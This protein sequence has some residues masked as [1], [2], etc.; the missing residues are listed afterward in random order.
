M[1]GKIERALKDNGY[2]LMH[3]NGEQTGYRIYYDS[4]ASLVNAV[5][6]V[7]AV[8]YN[9]E[10]STKF[11][12]ALSRQMAAYSMSTHFMTV[13]CVSGSP[14]KEI[15]EQAVVTQICED[16]SFC[17]VYDEAAEKL[18]IGEKQ[19]E[20]FYGLKHI[21][22][23][24]SGYEEQELEP[25]AL[26][27]ET[28]EKPRAKGNIFKEIASNIKKLPRA[29]SLLVFFNICIFVICTLTGP[30]LYNIGGAGLKLIEKP[31]D[32]YRIFTSMFLHLDAAHIF[33]NMVLLYFLGEIVEKCVGTKKFL[34]MYFFSGLWGC[35][36]T[37]FWEII[38]K[39]YVMVVGASGAIFGLLGGLFA[40]V[41]FKRIK[42]RT[43][44]VGRVFIVIIFSI[45]EG[46]AQ[47]NVANAAHIGG[48]VAGFLFGV[49]YCLINKNINRGENGQYEN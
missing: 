19:V 4:M 6:F 41:L 24:A 16:N 20:D 8:N 22:E 26:T 49:V 23:S 29:T 28:T 10:F 5:L 45:Y 21:L 34:F 37:F 38:S 14:D 12:E 30:L 7:D 47:I 42:A 18:F 17:W 11:K 46:F 13:I 44:P 9:E 36:A 33:G 35:L 2:R 27:G 40:L 48:L 31:Y 3:S 32:I 25:E 1:T 43:M 15:E 39:E